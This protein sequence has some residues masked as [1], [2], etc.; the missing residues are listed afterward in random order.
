MSILDALSKLDDQDDPKERLAAFRRA[1][2]LP[3]DAGLF[4]AFGSLQ[5]PDSS[6]PKQPG[7][8]LLEHNTAMW[9]R[10]YS[11]QPRY[12]LRDPVR[13]HVRHK[14]QPVVWRDFACRAQA[15]DDEAVLWRRVWDLGVSN[16]ITVPIHDARHGRYGSLAVVSFG[17][18]DEFDDWYRGARDTL[19]AK[20]YYFHH[21]L[22]EPCCEAPGDGLSLTKRERECL[23]LVARGYCS[24][25]IARRLEISPRTVDLH[26]ARAAERLGAR[27]R[28]HAV[29][30]AMKRGLIDA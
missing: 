14:F 21:G 25:A 1:L 24:K 5:R 26:I 30:K 22:D 18:R 6:G 12:R 17:R 7:R 23:S 13:R 16:G 19:A 4:Y 11:E 10:D 15:R 8:L 29:S 20:V 27:G 2:A 28:I 9:W 3:V